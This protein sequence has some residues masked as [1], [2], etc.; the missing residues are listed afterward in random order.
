[1]NLEKLL[2]NTFKCAY[3]DKYK[4]DL[5]KEDYDSTL[6]NL[7]DIKE[8]ICLFA[9][10]R[11]DLHNAINENIDVD[12]IK[13]M[14][15]HNAIEPQYIFKLIVY[16]VEKI[17]EFDCIANE[18]FHEAWKAKT[19]LALEEKGKLSEVFP[20][21]FKE[22]FFRIEKIEYEIECFKKTEIYAAMKRKIE[23]KNN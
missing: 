9:P 14:I 6:K 2:E 1:M 19:C 4:E 8:R 5:E 3:W 15:E 16:I 22:C 7:N 18:G 21:F 13:Q 20:D 12:Y 17:K 10:N 11:K 23:E